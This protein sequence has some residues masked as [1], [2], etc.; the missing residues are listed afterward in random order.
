MIYTAAYKHKNYLANKALC[1]ARSMARYRERKIVVDAAKN[2]PCTDCGIQY[3]YYIMQFDHRPDELKLFNVGRGLTG[4]NIATL[5]TEIEK[6][7]VVC[8]NC[9]WRRTFRRRGL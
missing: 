5:K 2:R 7:D 3:E 9:H 6:C 1:A 8:A 4:R